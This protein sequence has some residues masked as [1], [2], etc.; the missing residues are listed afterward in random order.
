MPSRIELESACDTGYLSLTPMFLNSFFSW[1][2]FK[3]KLWTSKSMNESILIK[4]ASFVYI[5]NFDHQFNIHFFI[6][7]SP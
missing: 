7:L 4:E 2:L 1:K 5:Y 6:W 3:L